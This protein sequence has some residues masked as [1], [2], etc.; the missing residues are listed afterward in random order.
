MDILLRILEFKT[1][2]TVIICSSLMKV[3][4]KSNNDA[5]KISEL[6]AKLFQNLITPNG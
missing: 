5:K 6:V 1:K 4:I 3:R 2:T